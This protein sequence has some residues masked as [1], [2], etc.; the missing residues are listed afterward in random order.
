MSDQ[1]EPAAIPKTAVEPTQ[2]PIP[3]PE[4]PVIPTVSVEPSGGAILNST[5][6]ADL[7]QEP[8][9]TTP[10]PLQKPEFHDDE[11]KPY[12]QEDLGNLNNATSTV[13]EQPNVTVPPPPTTGYFSERPAIGKDLGTW[14]TL[15]AKPQIP[16]NP[17]VTSESTH[18]PTEITPAQP[19]TQKSLLRRIFRR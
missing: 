1:A 5:S 11:T 2:F 4:L 3:T 8:L 18:Q 16:T 17:T 13:V 9:P 14:T 19:P 7:T 10:P 6:G 15:P 12:S